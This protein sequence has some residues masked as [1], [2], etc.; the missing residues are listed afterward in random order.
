VS[1]LHGYILRELLRNFALALVTLTALFT[2]GGGLF[3][4]LHPQGISGSEVFRFMPLLLPVVVTLTMPMA[5]LFAATIA[6]GRLAADNELQAC[7]AAGINIHRLFLAALLLSLFVTLFS[8]V[9][10]NYVIPSFVRQLEGL[11]RSNVRDYV[12][13][14]LN[15]KGHVHY[16]DY[17]LTAEEALGLED[18]KEQM[19]ARNFPVGPGY[20]YIY[21]RAPTMLEL[22]HGRLNRFTTASYAVCQFDTQQAD[23]VWVTLWVG[24]ARDFQ[25]GRSAMEIE[26]QQLGTV[27]LP[28]RFPSKPA[29][30]AL[31]TLFE[32]RRAP[33]RA[34]RIAA[35]LQQFRLAL[36]RE[37]FR[38]EAIERLRRGE[39][40]ELFDLA[41][42]R[43][44]I[45][46]GG[47]TTDR[48]GDPLLQDARILASLPGQAAPTRYQAPRVEMVVRMPR[49][50]RLVADWD[51][52]MID[53]RLRATDQ[54][55]VREYSP[56]GG[57]SGA[58][59]E[60]LSLIL[61]RLSTPPHIEQRVAALKDRE[62]MTHPPDLSLSEDLADR[63]AALQKTAD[64][65]QRRLEGLIHSRV[66][67][68]LSALVTIVMGAVLGVL[69][70]GS[71][72]LA[73]FGL[74]CIPLGTVTILTLMGRQLVEN[75]GT[76][77]VG[78]GVIWGG[79]VAAGLAD[80]TL[81]RLGVAR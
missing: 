60:N 59:R 31:G 32:W 45:R 30:Q 17:Y 81:I 57:G 68:S 76:E 48:N 67:Y 11:L 61:D 39:S 46:C 5:A 64:R 71:R 44:E 6:Y 78:L 24:R 15:T 66:A 42:Q 23:S 38:V 75:P 56:V 28:V 35:P 3:N 62:L 20:G 72:A 58:P 74:A 70:R 49:A 25:V 21:L 9:F 7:R 65:F 8:L 69:F 52:V 55:R 33:W 40:L 36:T 29:W 26:G 18:A 63:Q 73:A 19:E 43:Y 14:Q 41:G 51:R 54:E 34:E 4:V 80:V 27:R 22:D 16:G 50:D 53:L 2:M 13:Q 12:F 79:L 37:W 1:V 47:C 77:M 10:G